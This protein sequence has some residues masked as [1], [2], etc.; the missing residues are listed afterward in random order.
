MSV[1]RL[2]SA[3]LISKIISS[4]ILV[5]NLNETLPIPELPTI[6][7]P[8]P[9]PPPPFSPLTTIANLRFR[10]TNSPETLQQTSSSRDLSTNSVLNEF[11]TSTTNFKNFTSSSS[12]T[13]PTLQNP[14]GFNSCQNGKII[15][16]TNIKQQI[17]INSFYCQCF[18][19]Y[20]GENCEFY[21][22][23]L[24]C[25]NSGIPLDGTCLCTLTAF[26]GKR[27]EILSLPPCLPNPCD[28]VEKEN[29]DYLLV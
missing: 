28:T 2:V 22:E 23:D 27:C 13:V 21:S 14:A 3:S 17:F 6:L 29:S 8:P 5:E 16:L 10:T 24:T 7:T 20:F 15:D 18:D 25:L 9:P 19:G 26:S 1:S 12:S 11:L 4:Q